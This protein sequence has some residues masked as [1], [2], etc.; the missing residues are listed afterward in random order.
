MAKVRFGEPEIEN[1][2]NL[3]E[4]ETIKVYV[5]KGLE[6]KGDSIYI[7]LSNFLGLFKSIEVSGFKLL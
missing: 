3:Y 1:S 5:V 6:V 7:K 4:S 2:Y